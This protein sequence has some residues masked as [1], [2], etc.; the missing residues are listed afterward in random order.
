MHFTAVCKPCLWSYCQSPVHK[1]A[2]AGSAVGG[3][4]VNTASQGWPVSGAYAGPRAWPLKAHF[5]RSGPL[6]PPAREARPSQRFTAR[7]SPRLPPGGLC[8]HRQKAAL[9]SRI[10]KPLMQ[11]SGIL[12]GL[13]RM[14][15][16]RTLCCS[17][18]L[19]YPDNSI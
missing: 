5:A 14:D 9:C 13:P 1:Q 2:Y 8:S 19:R 4:E 10:W 6:A 16:P 17:S 12:R 3:Q 15:P 18:S 11:L 7:P